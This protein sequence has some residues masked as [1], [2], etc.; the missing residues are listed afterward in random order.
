MVWIK[1]D[2]QNFDSKPLAC[3]PA[4]FPAKNS[5]N[6]AKSNRISPGKGRGDTVLIFTYLD[7]PMTEVFWHYYLFISISAILRGKR[8]VKVGPKVLTLGPSFFHKNS[9]PSKNFRAM[10]LFA[11]VPLSEN[12]G[13]IGP[14][15]GVIVRAQKSPKKGNFVD[16]ESVRKHF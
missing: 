13:N 2:Q 5:P 7:R 6:I 10:F 16:A 12:F 3:D 1:Q 11:R 9:N 14:Y 15:L 4:L 8:R